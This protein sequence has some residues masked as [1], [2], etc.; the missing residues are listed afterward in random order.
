MEDLASFVRCYELELEGLT[1]LAFVACGD[2]ASAEDAVADAVVKV[3]A[4]WRKDE[5]ENLG[6]YL[7]RAVVNELVDRGRRRRR[8]Q[9]R[10]ALIVVGDARS[11]EDVVVDRES[12]W[13]ALQGL[14]IEHRVV[15]A[16]RYYCDLSESQTAEALGVPLGTIKSRASRGLQLLRVVFTKVGPDG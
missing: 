16:L 5:I 12:L 2:L 11:I 13:R 6:A 10:E 9:A 15:L 3:W 1:R 4:R 7:R 8:R 14:P